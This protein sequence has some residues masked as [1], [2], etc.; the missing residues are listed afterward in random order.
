MQF[1][2]QLRW[3]LGIK[4]LIPEWKSLLSPQFLKNDLFAGITI[5]L[6]AIPLSLAIA[7]ASGVSPGAGLISAI[8][9]GIV[10]AL[11]GGSRLSV[12]GPAAAMSVLIADTVEKMGIE[13]LFFVGFL[14]GLMQV[15]SGI[16]GFGRLGRY[17]PIPVI[18]GFTAGIG[19][20]ILIGQLPRAFGLLPPAES[21]TIDVLLHVKKYFHLVNWTCFSLTVFTILVIRLLPKILPKIPSV[22]VAVIA[23][24]LIV[25]FFHL[26]VPLIG[27][28]P[29]TLPS[30]HFPPYP[31]FNFSEVIFIAFS[32]FLL[33]SL[34]TLLSTTAIDKLTQTKKHDPN[35]ELVGQGLGN[36]L[37]SVF[38]GIPITGVI[39]R[40]AANIRA[41]AKTRRAS[42]IHSL[43]ILLT[44]FAIAPLISQIP[45]VA[46]AG[47]L[48][49]VAFSMISYRELRNFFKTDFTEGLIY[50]I[51][52]LT[53]ISVDLIA[54]VQAGMVAA[55][56]ILLIKAA[57]TNLHFTSSSEDS[58]M[59]LS[60]AGSL[61]FLSSSEFSALENKL[62]TIKPEQIVVIDLMNVTNMDSS[63]ASAIV[64][65][66][67]YSQSRQIQFYIK[68][69]QRRFERLMILNGGKD[70][71]ENHYLLSENQLKNS[72][73]PSQ[74]TSSHERLIHGVRL[75]YNECER[76]DRRLFEF[77]ASTQDPHTLFVT[78]SDSRMVPNLLTSTEPGELFI[79]RNVGNCIPPYGSLSIFS[80]AAAFEFALTNLDISDIVICGH[81]NCGAMRACKDL[82]TK[83]ESQTPKLS[84]WIEIM[85]SQLKLNKDIS[86][87]EVAKLNILNQMENLKKYPVVQQRIASEKPLAIYG[88]FFCFEENLVYEWDEN[89]NSFKPIE[90]IEL[91]NQNT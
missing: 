57:K 91:K 84:S 75:F 27:A 24:S 50:V 79:V 86:I 48:F 67:Q 42:I 5:G 63:G 33:A 90:R 6:I 1:L 73:S 39:V 30:P 4:T 59:R 45:I 74:V 28:V 16:L 71:L 43:L 26:D 85:Q 54:G 68:G 9:A 83:A 12:S 56:I 17:V 18:A 3:D 53:I 51:T 60:I 88:W 80:E 89:E 64:D 81:S 29:R 32:I 62:E 2:N 14:A 65:L 20:I 55:A 70:I 25:S 11:F 41:G 52:F 61:T 23:T 22:L 31:D 44:V 35:Q 46:L 34:E 15:V 49:S 66:Y 78:C 7:L 69:L 40:S 87:N 47:V 13:G 38:G 58:V 8:V 36:M 37:V 77:I 10:C 72:L 21:Q 76:H 82:N 19:V